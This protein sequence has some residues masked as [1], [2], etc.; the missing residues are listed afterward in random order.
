[1][2]DII[3]YIVGYY[4]GIVKYYWTIL[5]LMVSHQVLHDTCK[6][7]YDIFAVGIDLGMMAHH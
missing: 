7:L 2:L 1:M 5:Y 6:M 4:D 3:L